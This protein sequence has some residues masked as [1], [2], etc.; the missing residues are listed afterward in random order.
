MT[1]VANRGVYQA[2]YNLP[3]IINI[4]AAAAVAQ[5]LL[6]Q[7]QWRWGYGMIP[8]MIVGTGTPLLIGLWHG[9]IKERR[10]KKQGKQETLSEKVPPAEQKNIFQKMYW[11]AVEI[12]LIGSLFLVAALCLILLPLI[13]ARTSWGGWGSSLTIGTLVSG[14][15]ALILFV[16]WEWKFAT[17]SIV[18]MTS[19]KSTTPLLGVLALSIKKALVSMFMFQYFL[20]YLQV[21][22]D[23]T[24]KTA[25][26]LERGFNVTFIGFQIIVGYIM[27]RTRRWRP[28]VIA[29]CTIIIFGLG[30]MIPARRPTSSNAFLAISQI[31]TGV[32]V[33]MMHIPL[34][35]GVQST[36]PRKDL[37][38]VTALL[39]VG[40]S[41]ATSIGSAIGGSIWNSLIPAALQRHVPGHYD[42]LK[43]VKSIPYT[44]SLPKE[45]LDGVIAAY[46][47]VMNTLSI[48]MVCIA[49]L[50]LLVSFPI[51]SFGFK[52][53]EEED[54]LTAA[55]STADD[56]SEKRDNEDLSPE[57]AQVAAKVA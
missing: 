50:P 44:K 6:Q 37:A 27:T 45:Q 57:D 11:L 15:A 5:E 16:I 26:Y 3:E 52:E 25:I 56:T 22:R 4:F 24:P 29:G 41:I 18:P 19:W 32:G 14:C 30:L 2:L 1:E 9:Q 8:I 42:Y 40:Q 38:I 35:V 36:V 48:V 17:K 51:K 7:N 21:T 55:S 34:M 31:I 39:Q 49:V 10:K 13:L 33:G 46:G 12:D 23:V 53:E 43:I 47:E 54:Q 28:I 20:T